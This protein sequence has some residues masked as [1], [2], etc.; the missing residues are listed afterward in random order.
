MET[1]VFKQ[2]AAEVFKKNSFT[3]KGNYFRKTGDGVTAVI[4]LQRSNF[5][6]AYYINAGFSIEEIH[7][8]L[9]EPKDYECDLSNRMEITI[10]EKKTSLFDL[11][12]IRLSHDRRDK[13]NLLSVW[14]DGE[15]LYMDEYIFKDVFNSDI[16]TRRVPPEVFVDNLAFFFEKEGTS[17]LEGKRSVLKTMRRYYDDKIHHDAMEF[18]IPARPGHSG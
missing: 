3:K 7:P 10:D 8:G 9:K 14:H 1:E 15:S 4:N 18:I 5:S 17:L 12:I 13:S 2:T 6:K 16:K 11:D